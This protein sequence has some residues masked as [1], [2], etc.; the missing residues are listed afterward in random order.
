MT[1]EV[2]VEPI[3]RIFCA[4]AGAEL[5]RRNALERLARHLSPAA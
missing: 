2:L 3:F 5:E 4:R 1:E